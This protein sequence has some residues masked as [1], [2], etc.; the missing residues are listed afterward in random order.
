MIALPKR[1]AK[2]F[3]QRFYLHTMLRQVLDQF[4]FVFERPRLQTHPKCC[5][6]EQSEGPWFLLDAAALTARANT[7]VPRSARDD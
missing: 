6:P 5:H 7:K 3:Y 4:E 1:T 2:L